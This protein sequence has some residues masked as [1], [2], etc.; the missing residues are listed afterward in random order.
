MIRSTIIYG[1]HTKELPR[2]LLRRLE[3]YMYKQIRTMMNPCWVEEAWYPKRQPYQKTKQSTMESWMDKTQITT[4][5]TQTKDAKT[6]HPK[7]RKEMLIPR[8]ILQTQWGIMNHAIQEH[9]QQNTRGMPLSIYEIHQ[10]SGKTEITQLV[11]RHPDMPNELE[12]NRE[13]REQVSELMLEYPTEQGNRE[14]GKQE[15]EQR[16][17]YTCIRSGKPFETS[18]GATNRRKRSPECR[19]VHRAEVFENKCQE[20]HIDF[21]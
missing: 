6:I 18:I 15:E 1:L 10:K 4:M 9:A 17:Y 13:D 5:A 7:H 12:L 16:R 11:A 14:E 3:T 2:N 8:N 20:R 21:R 19:Q